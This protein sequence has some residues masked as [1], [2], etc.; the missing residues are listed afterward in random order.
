MESIAGQEVAIL[1]GV[2]MLAMLCMALAL[3]GFFGKTQRKLLAQ[4]LASQEQI[5]QGTL[6]AQEEERSRIAKDLHDDIGS[7]LNVAFLH[8]QRLNNNPERTTEIVSEISE[9]LNTTIDATRRISHE[10]LPPTLQ[11]FGL[12]EALKE[13]CE[14]YTKTG[15]VTFDLQVK[16]V[17]S[18]V[19]SPEK[20]LHLFRLLQEL[21]KNSIVHGKAKLI[22][23]HFIT[24]G[25]G[26]HFHYQDDG[27]GFDAH[28]SKPK[29]LGMSNIDSRIKLIKGHWSFDTAP[30]KGF[31]AQIN[32]DH[33]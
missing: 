27:Q 24:G 21:I 23:I 26:P 15:Y 7:K 9:I 29:G 5:L 18:H 3:V 17:A 4:K 22:Q 25:T 28:T 16:A 33:A 8:T 32:L 13:L 12:A 30:G 10:L 20:S 31:T 2:S 6:L 19:T 1:I 11:K 14:G